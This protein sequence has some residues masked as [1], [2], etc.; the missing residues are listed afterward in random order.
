VGAPIDGSAWMTGDC[1]KHV[2]RG[3][4]W[5]GANLRSADRGSTNESSGR[6]SFLGFR[7]ARVL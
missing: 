6:Y 3:G 7:V 5:I 1:R 4:E 2:F